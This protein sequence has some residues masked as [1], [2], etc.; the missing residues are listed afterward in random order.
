MEYTTY[1]MNNTSLTCECNFLERNWFHGS[2]NWVLDWLDDCE[3][4]LKKKQLFI[5]YMFFIDSNI[6]SALKKVKTF[7]KSEYQIVY[8]HIWMCI[9]LRE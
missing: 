8:T 2:A 7:Y 3:F 6:L 4:M 9:K 5:P 1:Q